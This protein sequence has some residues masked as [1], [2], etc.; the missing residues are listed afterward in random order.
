MKKLLVLTALFLVIA[1]ALMAADS[2]LVNLSSLQTEGKFGLTAKLNWDVYRLDRWT[3][4]GP[5]W[6]KEQGVSEYT[7]RVLCAEDDKFQQAVKEQTIT[8]ASEASFSGLA[9]GKKYFFEV[10]VSGNDVEDV[11]VWYAE[12][13]SKEYHTATLESERNFFAQPVGFIKLVTN[14]YENGGFVGLILML[15]AAM[16]IVLAITSFIRFNGSLAVPFEEGISYGGRFLMTLRRSF[17]MASVIEKNKP[18]QQMMEKAKQFLKDYDVIQKYGDSLWEK[19]L[20]TQRQKRVELWCELD[21]N[22]R[23]K[24]LIEC[25]NR[26]E[27]T[28]PVSVSVVKDVLRQYYNTFEHPSSSQKMNEIIHDSIQR[29]S[30]RLRGIS[31]HRIKDLFGIDFFW[32]I[33]G[34]A[35]MLGLFGTVLGISKAFFEIAMNSNLASGELIQQLAGGINE[36]LYTTIGGLFVGIP[37]VLFYYYFHNKLIAYENALLDS[38]L[39]LMKHRQ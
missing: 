1:T 31:G 27:K 18:H 28:Q 8:G 34:L 39:E 3:S 14:F 16:G 22:Q 13:K 10:S 19:D 36:A 35:P 20:E 2:L 5:F 38:V 7:F 25:C 4:Q 6:M 21:A 30:Y 11:S 23:M 17:R 15:F 24:D 9:V 29:A 12:M 32:S 26:E 37:M 33:G